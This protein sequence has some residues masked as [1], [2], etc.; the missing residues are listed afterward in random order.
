MLKSI[1][2]QKGFIALTTVLLVL[3][4]TLAVGISVGLGSII[5]MQASLQKNQSSV[6]YYLAN[7]CVEEA[8]MKLKE[9]INYIGNE[10]INL[11]G[12]SCTILPVEG[13]WTIKTSA[14]YSNQIKKIKII[15]SQVNPQ[16]VISS[17]EEVASF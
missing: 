4:I 3:V 12:G 5:E 8:L 14:N 10:T 1:K 13:S 16:M 17:W 11:S 6:T 9:D 2:E 7:L 15:V